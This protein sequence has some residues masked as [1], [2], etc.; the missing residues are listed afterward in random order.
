M[1]PD[2]APVR[3]VWREEELKVVQALGPEKIAAEWWNTNALQ[4]GEREYFRLL[5]M[6]GRWLWVFRD[7]ASQQWF[8]HGMWQ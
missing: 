1:L 6:K 4:M 8:M 3:I 2:R 5:D 7:N